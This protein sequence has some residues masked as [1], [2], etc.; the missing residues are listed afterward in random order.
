MGFQGRGEMEKVRDGLRTLL[1]FKFPVTEVD[2]NYLGIF[3]S[4]YTFPPA[5]QQVRE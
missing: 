5:K 1:L 2:L 3:R 4:R